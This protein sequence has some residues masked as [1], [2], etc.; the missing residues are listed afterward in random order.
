MTET[1]ERQYLKIPECPVAAINTYIKRLKDKKAVSY[2][3]KKYSY[4]KLF[5]DF[6]GVEIDILR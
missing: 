2:K 3:D 4:S 5:S 6:D 1:I